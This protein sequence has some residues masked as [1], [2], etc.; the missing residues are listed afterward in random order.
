MVTHL[1]ADLLRFQAVQNNP[2]RSLGA[3]VDS[4]TWNIGR[5]KIW[6]SRLRMIRHYFHTKRRTMSASVTDVVHNGAA[7]P[8]ARSIIDRFD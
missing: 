6:I 5:R 7:V 4:Q 2:G 8:T 3:D 1:R